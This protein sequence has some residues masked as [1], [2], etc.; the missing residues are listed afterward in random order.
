MLHLGHFAGM[1][2]AV[3]PHVKEYRPLARG[4]RFALGYGMARGWS[5]SDFIRRVSR[6]AKELG[7]SLAQ[8]SVAAGLSEDALRKSPESRLIGTIE[9]IGGV[10][11]WTLAETL[12]L[13]DRTVLNQDSLRLAIVVANRATR[14]MRAD[15]R[16][17]SMPAIAAAVY[18]PLADKAAS[19]VV[20]SDDDIAITMMDGIVLAVL[21]ETGRN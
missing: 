6:R 3:K 16:A 15:E 4:T 12:G 21:R 19:G 1:N 10:L 13:E 5:E 14:G 17:A 2:S 20:V 8:V 7:L 11:G 18:Q 9:S